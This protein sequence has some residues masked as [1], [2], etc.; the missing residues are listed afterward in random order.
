MVLQL[1]LR[2]GT[3]DSYSEACLHPHA[4]VRC[5]HLNTGLLLGH[6]N[7]QCFVQ[8]PRVVGIQVDSQI[9]RRAIELIRSF[10]LHNAAKL[11]HKVR[12][13]LVGNGEEYLITN[14]LHALFKRFGFGDRMPI[15]RRDRLLAKTFVEFL[16]HPA[17]QA[18][19]AGRRIVENAPVGPNRS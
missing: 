2:I 10:L 9:V 17:Q 6:E 8:V 13:V 3:E 5:P 12:T 14:L 4:H 15:G 7:L 18:P 11:A 1:E 16:E 19:L